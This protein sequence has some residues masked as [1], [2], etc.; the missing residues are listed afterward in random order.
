[1]PQAIEMYIL[2]LCIS[3][4]FSTIHYQQN[5][6][7]I[8]CPGFQ[9]KMQKTSISL[10]L[11]TMKPNHQSTENENWF[12]FFCCNFH[13][14]NEQKNEE[15]AARTLHAQRTFYS[16]LCACCMST[17]NKLKVF[18]YFCFLLLLSSLVWHSIFFKFSISSC[19]LKFITNRSSLFQSIRI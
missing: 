18:L 13:D 5:I 4:L 11:K 1:M 15:K 2:N 9:L 17:T 8:V 10:K 3:K 19:Q 12:K 16:E 14:K 7:F 6:Q